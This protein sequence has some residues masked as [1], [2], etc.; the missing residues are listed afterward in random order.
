MK[1]IESIIFSAFAL[2]AA[3]SSCTDY[4]DE[5]AGESVSMDNEIQITAMLDDEVATRAMSFNS[6]TLTTANIK[7]FYMNA[8]KSDDSALISIAKSGDNY[9]TGKFTPVTEEE[10]EA[11]AG[12]EK[13]TDGASLPYYWPTGN[14]KFMAIACSDGTQPAI[15]IA[16]SGLTMTDFQVEKSSGEEVVGEADFLTQQDYIAAVTTANADDSFT[17]GLQFQHLLSRL[18]LNMWAPQDKFT[19]T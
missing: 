8:Y 17:V 12:T 4:L 5:A 16:K 6:A 10:Q 7:A 2:T 11:L 13:W 18:S 1:K 9:T 15:S 14:V 3:L 19:H